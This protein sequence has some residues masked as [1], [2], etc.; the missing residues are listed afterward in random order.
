[1]AK[2]FSDGKVFK[3]SVDFPAGSVIGIDGHPW[4]SA[5]QGT[6]FSGMSIAL[7]APEGS[8]GMWIVNGAE[9]A[10]QDAEISI[11]VDKDLT[12]S[13]SPR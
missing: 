6:Y 5:Y 4:R 12:I 11:A 10:R 2:Q 7:R 9:Y 8:R 1:M 13:Y 3:V